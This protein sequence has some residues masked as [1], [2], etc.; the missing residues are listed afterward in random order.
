MG[1]V[2]R[3]CKMS[4]HDRAVYGARVLG[5]IGR[6]DRH[7]N[8]GDTKPC[9]SLDGANDHGEQGRGLVGQFSFRFGVAR[10]LF[11]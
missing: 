6:I 2:K 1:T 7:T 9:L 4:T 11:A 5:K 3:R 10:K 8:L